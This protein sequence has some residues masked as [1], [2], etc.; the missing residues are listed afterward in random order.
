MVIRQHN[1]VYG[2]VFGVNHGDDH[3]SESLDLLRIFILG[4]FGFFR[5]I[6]GSKPFNSDKCGCACA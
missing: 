4:W 3:I 2:F 6:Y 1:Y 5:H